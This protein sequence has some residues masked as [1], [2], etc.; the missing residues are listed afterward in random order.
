MPITKPSLR[1]GISYIGVNYET[2]TNYKDA[3]NINRIKDIPDDYYGSMGVP[4]TIMDY[5]NENEWEFL[6]PM[7]KPR[8]IRNGIETIIY[9][10]LMVRRKQHGQ[11]ST[12]SE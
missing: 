11:R 4:V 3:I 5:W 12:K 8:I 6:Q 10:R 9:Y 1:N 2:Y 7:V